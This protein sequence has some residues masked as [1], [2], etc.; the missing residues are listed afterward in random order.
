MTKEY[1]EQ[2][3]EDHIIAQAV[4]ILRGRLSDNGPKISSAKTCQDYLKL[5]LGLLDHEAF[6]VLFVDTQNQV[7]LCKEMFT[8]SLAQCSVYPREVA[9]AALKYNASSVILAHNHPSG[10]TKPSKADLELTKAL[11][12]ALGLID[13]CVLDHVIVAGAETYS[14]AE[15]G[16]I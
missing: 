12:S 5:K 6:W 11:V 9:R 13:V 15:Q 7:I 14:F 8:G 2:V 10:N 16:L 3:H 1:A 4:T